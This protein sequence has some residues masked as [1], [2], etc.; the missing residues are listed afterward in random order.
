MIKNSSFRLIC[1]VFA[2]CSLSSAGCSGQVSRIMVSPDTSVTMFVQR[3]KGEIFIELNFA[4][5]LRF[6]SAELERRPDFEGNFARFGYIAFDDVVAHCGYVIKKDNYPYHD[7]AD[8]YYRIKL[9]SENGKAH[10]FPAIM[11]PA[12]IHGG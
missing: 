1:S 8:V 7:S 4:D 5:N 12:A 10:I 9:V 3:I 11:L 6:T 2:V